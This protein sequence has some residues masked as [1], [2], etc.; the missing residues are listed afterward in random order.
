MQDPI[1]K[2]TR[3]K[4][5]GCMIQVAEHLPSQGKALNSNSTKKK[6]KSKKQSNPTFLWG[7]KKAFLPKVAP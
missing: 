4:R 1:E 7:L 2:I 6:N 3:A 5:A